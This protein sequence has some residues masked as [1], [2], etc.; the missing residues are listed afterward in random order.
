MSIESNK[1]LVRSFFE[2][3]GR[4]AAGE[5]TFERATE[6]ILSPDFRAHIPGE[7]DLDLDAFRDVLFAFVE[8]FPSFRVIL[9]EQIAEGDK[10]A[11]RAIFAGT[12]SSDYNGLAPTDREVAV[13]EIV[14]HRVE[15]GRIAEL[16]AQFDN[17]AIMK[18]LDIPLE[19]A[20]GPR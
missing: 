6:E 2:W 18:Q 8:G 20:R 7:K 12:N 16:W 3:E 19:Q 1:E 10:V 5:D 9:N 11:T 14:I 13:E 4:L 17:L 15:D